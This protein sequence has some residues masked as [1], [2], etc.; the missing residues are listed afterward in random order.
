MG[1]IVMSN[2]LS[3]DSV[4]RYM[5]A[6][7]PDIDALELVLYGDNQAIRIALNV[8]Y[9]AVV[10]KNTGCSVRVFDVL[11]AFHL[12]FLAS[13]YQAPKELSASGCFS[14]NNFRVFTEVTR[15]GH[16]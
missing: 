4:V 14:Q 9:D 8:E 15:M 7:K 6:D 12:A 16:A 2:L 11:R 3:L 5:G 1:F 13:V 10:R